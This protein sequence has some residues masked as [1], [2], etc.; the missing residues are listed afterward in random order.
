M[1]KKEKTQWLHSTILI[2][3]LATLL[4][5][6]SRDRNKHQEEDRVVLASFHLEGD[7]QL[8]FQL[9]K[10]EK[11]V[12]TWQEFHDGLDHRY[13]AT[14]FQDF[15]KELTK[16]QQIGSVRDYQTHFEK[17]LAKVGYLP[18]NRQVSCF[19]SGLKDSIKADVLAGCPASLS[20]A[21]GLASLYEARNA[22]QRR[23][24]STPDP[25]KVFPTNKDTTTS[26]SHPPVR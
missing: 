6:I 21:I 9:L 12:M 18:H 3:D 13:G 14:K 23:I 26:S 2:G 16:L 20:S 8:W 19:I 24:V 17:L 5:H 4:G 25:K 7:S 1:I 15:F 10:Q 11:G 22:A